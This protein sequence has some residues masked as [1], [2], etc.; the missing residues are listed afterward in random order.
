MYGKTRTRLFG[1][2][3]FTARDNCFLEDPWIVLI[4]NPIETSGVMKDSSVSS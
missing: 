3:K 2:L 1:Y 4:E